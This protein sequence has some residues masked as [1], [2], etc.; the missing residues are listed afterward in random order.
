M[1]KR[2]ELLIATNNQGKL[3][4]IRAI[5]KDLEVEL[6]SPA[7]LDLELEV[8][9]EP[10]APPVAGDADDVNG[11]QVDVGLRDLEDTAEQ[12]SSKIRFCLPETSD[13]S[14]NRSHT[15]GTKLWMA[16]L[17]TGSMFSYSSRS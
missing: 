5:L 3:K 13:C 8:A 9:L 10:G 12:A 14:T 17:I 16:R 1:T 11:A 15:I 2:T 6:V 4:E 7:D